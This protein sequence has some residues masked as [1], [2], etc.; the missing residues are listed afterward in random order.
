MADVLSWLGFFEEANGL[1]LETGGQ[2]RCYTSSGRRGFRRDMFEED[3]AQL[4]GKTPDL[5]TVSA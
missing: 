1:Q 3:S 5:P 2:P 4:V